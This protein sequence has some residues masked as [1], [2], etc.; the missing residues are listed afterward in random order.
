ME[1]FEA[2]EKRYSHKDK[3]LPDAVPLG[4]LELIAR[5]GLAAPTGINTQCVRLII[6]PDKEALQPLCDAVPSNSLATAPAAIALLT[7]D[8]AQLPGRRHFDVEDY[9]A[10]AS[11]MSFAATALG[12][13]SLWLDNPY[14]SEEK[15]A[16]ALEA[17][18]VPAGYHLYVVM[19]IGLPDGEPS[20]REKMP[21][22]ARV[23]Y[24][25]FGGSKA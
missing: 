16:A 15:Q 19:P 14:V 25:K 4:D 10:A 12:Y 20:R 3:F 8:D 5:A 13:G 9:A 11:S 22:E 24:G 7:C 23:S 2:I 1:F 17:L 18:G 21:F 6:L